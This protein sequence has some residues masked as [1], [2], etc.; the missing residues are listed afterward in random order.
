MKSYWKTII[1]PIKKVFNCLK[2]IRISASIVFQIF[3]NAYGKNPVRCTLFPISWF[4]KLSN[5]LLQFSCIFL[6][7][8]LRIHMCLRSTYA[9]TA[10]TAME[11]NRWHGIFSRGERGSA[12]PRMLSEIFYAFYGIIANLRVETRECAKKSHGISGWRIP[13]SIAG[14]LRTDL[15]PLCGV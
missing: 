9:V 1:A 6:K 14:C 4:T 10:A 15:Y 7:H 12:P 8:P 3:R 13:E 5:T 11:I 2:F